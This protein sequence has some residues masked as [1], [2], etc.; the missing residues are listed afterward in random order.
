MRAANLRSSFPWTVRSGGFFFS[1][2]VRLF[3]A[4]LPQIASAVPERRA[5]PTYRRRY[6]C[7]V[8]ERDSS[9]HSF[10]DFSFFSALCFRGHHLRAETATDRESK[11][12]AEQRRGKEW[13][14]LL[15]KPNKSS[16]N[17]RGKSKRLACSFG[18]IERRSNGRRACAQVSD[19]TY[20]PYLSVWSSLA[21]ILHRHACMH[22]A[23]EF[24][25]FRFF[26]LFLHPIS[27]RHLPFFSL[28]P[29]PGLSCW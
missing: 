10:C 2:N 26:P 25:T 13:K 4:L 6:V 19:R 21:S 22:P 17:E 18:W 11:D 9:F 23:A 7:N 8:D 24:R 15:C 3:F 27:W 1:C 29:V 14:K 16:T 20:L 28:E 12:L 5:Y